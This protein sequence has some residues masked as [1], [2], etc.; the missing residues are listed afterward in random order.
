ML[1]AFEKTY[2]NLACNY[3]R[4]FVHFVSDDFVASWQGAA[5]GKIPVDGLQKHLDQQS[6]ANRL[7]SQRFKLGAWADN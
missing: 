2:L 6:S 7:V 1:I 3:F 5:L 4:S